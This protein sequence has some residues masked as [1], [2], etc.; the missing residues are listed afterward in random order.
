[1]P[2][3]SFYPI[4]VEFQDLFH[5]LISASNPASFESFIKNFEKDT[6]EKIYMPIDD[7]R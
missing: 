3:F 1:I 2:P 7:L 6:G 5:K 4:N